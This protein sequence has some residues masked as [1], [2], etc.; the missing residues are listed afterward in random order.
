MVLYKATLKEKVG[1]TIRTERCNAFSFVIANVPCFIQVWN[2]KCKASSQLFTNV[3][4]R[5]KQDL[6]RGTVQHMKYNSF[7]GCFYI[8]S[9][10]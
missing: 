4:G 10:N 9:Q 8:K 2:Q 7:T 5:K 3:V 6:G 1:S